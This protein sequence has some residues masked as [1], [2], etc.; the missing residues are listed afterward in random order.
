MQ[1]PKVKMRFSRSKINYLLSNYFAY[2]LNFFSGLILAR[3]LGPENRGIFSYLSNL[4]L[5]TLF[6]APLN[7]KNAASIAQANLNVFEKPSIRKLNRSNLY[8]ISFILCSFLSL[9]Y[10]LFLKNRFE[11]KIILIFCIS[12]LFNSFAILNQIEEGKFRTQHRLQELAV[13]RFL[14]YATPSFLIFLLF[15]LNRVKIEYVIVG[16]A[17]AMSSCFCYLF[18]LK[19]SDNNLSAIS[20]TRGI[21]NTYVSFAAEYF[22][23]FI[24]LIF[25]SYTENLTYLGLFAIAYGYSLIADTYFQ[26]IE[27]RLYFDL[28]N[29]NQSDSNKVRKLFPKN[30]LNLL[31]SQLVFVPAA[32][33][34]PYLYGAA[35][36]KSS[37][38]AVILIGSKF[39]YSVVKLE[40]IYFNVLFQKFRIPITLNFG[41]LILAVSSFI[42]SDHLFAIQHSWIVSIVIAGIGISLTGCFLLL[43]D[44]RNDND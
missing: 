22:V 30:I 5:V 2:V 21:K 33:L 44:L 1:V 13:L 40:N 39:L 23:N 28:A 18:L 12:N 42:V 17:I 27:S 35:Y 26:V 19:K 29:P 43:R 3:K 8:F 10:L 14:G 15:I 16:Q 36:E 7:A 41:Y 11:M 25:V 32:Y 24:P 37:N 4:Y 6:L 38:L 9:I 20:F 31:V 34:I